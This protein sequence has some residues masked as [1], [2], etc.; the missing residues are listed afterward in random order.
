MIDDT[1]V[2]RVE[3][4]R[5]SVEE[6]RA[7]LKGRYRS[8]DRPVS[9]PTLRDS[10]AQLGERWLVEIAGRDDVLRILGHDIVADLNVEFQRLITFSEQ[11]TK[12]GRYDSALKAIASDFRTRVIVPLKQARNRAAGQTQPP[13]TAADSPKAEVVFVGQSFLPNDAVINSA[14]ARVVEAF[15][16]TVTTGE[17]PRA[18][19]VS[20][21][22]RDRIEA[23]TVF[24]GIFTRRDRVR[25][26]EW[27]TS[28]WVID[29]KAYALATRKK[30]ILLREAG[31][32]SI[33]GIQGDYEYIEFAR[34][35][36]VELMVKL[37]QTLRSLQD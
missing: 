7:E 3:R 21:K 18:D 16:F 35:D 14:V 22:V 13:E 28:S 9:A 12:R 26:N 15:G 19:S 11:Q 32:Q 6:L 1:M 4:L 17:K 27:T 5:D 31:V 10:A 24:V 2:L 25:R 30:L 23:A 20:K 34:E 8:A 36:L 29:E 37:V 33:G